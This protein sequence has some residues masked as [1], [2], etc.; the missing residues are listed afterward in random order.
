DPGGL[1]AEV[2]RQLARWPKHRMAEDLSQRYAGWLRAFAALA[3]GRAALAREHV[4]ELE[5][6]ELIRR[7]LTPHALRAEIELLRGLIHVAAPALQRE[8]VQRS[9]ARLEADP[10]PYGGAFAHTLRAALAL[11]AG[12]S[13]THALAA[14]ELAARRGGLSALAASAS[15][16][17]ALVSSQSLG[18]PDGRMFLRAQG[19]VHPERFARFWFA[20]WTLEQR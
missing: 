11:R 19:V 9:I 20:P 16:M 3:S 13:A 17:Q 12:R 1:L 15:A 10:R 2:E 8:R 14:A 5:R 4:A 6:G 18:G 7:A